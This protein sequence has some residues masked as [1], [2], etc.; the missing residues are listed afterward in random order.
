MM[1]ITATRNPN[2]QI[3]IEEQEPIRTQ[4]NGEDNNKKKT[5]I[6]T[7]NGNNEFRPITSTTKLTDSN[8]ITKKHKG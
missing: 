3:L 8:Q 2:P 4:E 7:L 6:P 5:P 1:R